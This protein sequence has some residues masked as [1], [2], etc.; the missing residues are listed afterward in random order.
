[1]TGP[2]SQQA[3][4]SPI[5]SSTDQYREVGIATEIRRPALGNRSQSGSSVS[6]ESS[7]RSEVSHHAICSCT[8]TATAL[9]IGNWELSIPPSSMGVNLLYRA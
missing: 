2:G 9:T 5:H 1:M 7:N 6:G 8:S 3:Q 4:N